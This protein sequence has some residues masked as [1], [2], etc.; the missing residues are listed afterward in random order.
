MCPQGQLINISSPFILSYYINRGIQ[1][2]EIQQE[3]GKLFCKVPWHPNINGL[4][5]VSAVTTFLQ[6]TPVSMAQLLVNSSKLHQRQKDK[7]LSHKNANIQVPWG[8]S[9]LSPYKV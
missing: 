9:A 7:E 3:T 6:R 4:K 8:V 5:S 1:N 2:S